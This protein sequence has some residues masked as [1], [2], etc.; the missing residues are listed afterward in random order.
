VT[1]TPSGGPKSP[2]SIRRQQRMA[3]WIA[4]H[5]HTVAVALTLLI[6]VDVA[7]AVVTVVHG[8]R[9]SDVVTPLTGCAGPGIAL[10]LLPAIR[11]RAS[12]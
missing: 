10:A 3:R 4:A 6:V 5:A 2:A 12:E 7:T 1:T 11:R 9:W 8:G